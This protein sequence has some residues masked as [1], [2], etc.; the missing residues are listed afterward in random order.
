MV[1]NGVLVL[2][3]SVLE[4]GRCKGV[5][6][7]GS[8]GMT[9][10]AAESKTEGESAVPGVGDMVLM[11]AEGSGPA[12][13]TG[14]IVLLFLGAVRSRGGLVAFDVIGG[15]AFAGVGVSERAGDGVFAGGV[16]RNVGSGEL[17]LAVAFLRTATES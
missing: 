12:G 11:G 8:E 5:V 14:R 13:S 15:V 16:L 9:W 1:C 4:A 2:V 7:L 3:S 17:V 6:T 10:V